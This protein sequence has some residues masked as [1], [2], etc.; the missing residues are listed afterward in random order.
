MWNETIFQYLALWLYESVLV[1]KTTLFQ[2][3]FSKKVSKHCMSF[4]N[5]K[6]TKSKVVFTAG[7]T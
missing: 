6:T 5:S 4:V 3:I 7:A 1:F 2:I